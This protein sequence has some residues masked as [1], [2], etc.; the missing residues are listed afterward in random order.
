MSETAVETPAA[1]TQ[2]AVDA[3]PSYEAAAASLLDVAMPGIEPGKPA[4]TKNASGNDGAG[5]TKDAQGTEAKTSA[6]DATIAGTEGK[7]DGDSA[8]KAADDWNI[9]QALLDKL[10]A[11]PNHGAFAKSLFEKYQKMAGY[12]EFWTLDEAKAARALAPG[13]IAELTTQVERGKAAAIEQAQFASGKPEEQKAALL[14]IAEEMPEQFVAGIPVYM[15]LVAQQNP[16]AYARIMKAE[17]TRALETDGV[18]SMLQ[19]LFEASEGD[20]NDQKQQEA[21][22]NAF[23]QVREWADKAGFSK[24][25]NTAKTAEMSPELKAANERIKEFEQQK[26]DGFRVWGEATNKEM[27]AAVRAELETKLSDW[28]PPNTDKTFKEIML[29]RLL[30]EAERKIVQ[31]L[32]SDPDL[33][34]KLGAVLEKDAWQKDGPGSRTQYLNLSIS[35]VKQIAPHVVSE[36]TKSAATHTVKRAEEKNAREMA[37]SATADVTGSAGG[38]AAKVPFTVKDVRRGGALTAKTD[39]EI[40]DM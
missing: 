40:L 4:E 32:T 31:Q 24:K 35:R 21:F 19:A 14:A 28:F 37:K 9:D 33:Q 18:P 30:D 8:E 16:E 17:L 36:L 27:S 2:A 7:K 6:E 38:H 10:L 26:A 25:A 29:G 34:K 12:R 3:A 1:G 5:D 23:T 39:E 11:D 22:A 20:A 13:G 15:E